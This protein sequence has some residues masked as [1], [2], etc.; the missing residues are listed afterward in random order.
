MTARR[1]K[2][3]KDVFIRCAAAPERRLARDRVNKAEN[4]RKKAKV[5]RILADNNIG[6]IVIFPVLSCKPQ[7]SNNPLTAQRSACG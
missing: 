4:L 5:Q 1:I 2:N 3:G 6:E 7:N